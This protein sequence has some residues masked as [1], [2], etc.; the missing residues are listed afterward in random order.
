M[1]LP[2]RGSFGDLDRLRD[3]VSR[4][5]G[6]LPG[7]RWSGFGGGG[8]RGWSQDV[9]VDDADE[10]W[11]VRV[12]L[13]GVAPTEVQLEIEERELRVSAA[14]AADEPAHARADFRYRLTV[15]SDVEVDAAEA[16][17]DHGLLVIRLP[18]TRRGGARRIPVRP[19]GQ[20]R[21]SG[22]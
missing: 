18:R 9:E 16:T 15:P 19:G 22:S 2:L 14:Q 5:L 21:R 7:S 12:R 20:N 4:I 17:M 10:V 8:L 6:T 13:P 11:T 1:S 3:E